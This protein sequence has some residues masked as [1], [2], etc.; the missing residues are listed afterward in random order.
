MLIGLVKDMTN[1]DFG[2][3]RSKVKV[4]RVLFVNMVYAHFLE[5]YLS[6]S[7]YI[8]HADWSRWRH[9]PIDIEVTKSNVKFRRI[10]FVKKIPLI[11]LRTVYHRAFIYHML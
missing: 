4:K 11:I 1:I 8:K 7:V 6:Q 10:T 2:F 3:T 9:T 5:N